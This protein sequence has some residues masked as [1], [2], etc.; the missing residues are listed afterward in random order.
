MKIRLGF[1]RS[2]VLIALTP[3]VVWAEP[4]GSG[5]VDSAQQVPNDPLVRGGDARSVIDQSG[6]VA[7]LRNTESRGSGSFPSAPVRTS[8][9]AAARSGQLTATGPVRS[10]QAASAKAV[11][12]TRDHVAARPG[13]IKSLAGALTASSHR[14]TAGA[15]A[16]AQIGGARPPHLVPDRLTAPGP[17]LQ[18]PA[19]APGLANASPTT[20]VASVN[21]LARR[22]SANA[23]VGAAAV[24]EPPR[25]GALVVIGGTMMKRSRL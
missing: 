10:Q 8:A 23:V 9:A 15:S 24:S 2:I 21:A 6:P 13:S 1:F 19:H 16:P 3:A 17:R 7:S 12:N 11:S 14:S 20:P 18:A 22:S 4:L 25:N 5:L